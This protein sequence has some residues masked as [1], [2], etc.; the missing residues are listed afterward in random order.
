[1]VLQKSQLCWGESNKRNSYYY[2]IEAIRNGSGEACLLC[3]LHD[4]VD[5]DESKLQVKIPKP[6]E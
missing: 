2:V 6:S 5:Y 4:Y 3:F 1:M